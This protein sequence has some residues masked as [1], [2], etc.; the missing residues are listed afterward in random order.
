MT[1]QQPCERG[2]EWAHAGPPFKTALRM[3]VL[4]LAALARPSFANDSPSRFKGGRREGRMLAAPMA[5]VRMKMHGA[6][7]KGAS[8]T[9]GLSCAVVLTAYSALSPVH[10]AFWP[11]SPVRRE[12]VVASLASASGCQDHTAWPSASV[13]FVCSRIA[14]C[15]SDTSTASRARRSLRSRSA[16]LFKRGTSAGDIDF[17]KTKANY[18]SRQDWTGRIGLKGYQN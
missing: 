2:R 17:G 3:H 8:R 9:T 18:F 15:N 7:T 14:R 10:R 1:R 12:S 11:P 4:N 13:V 5:P 16:P 6:G